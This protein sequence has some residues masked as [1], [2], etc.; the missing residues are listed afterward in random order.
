MLAEKAIHALLMADSAVVALV[1]TRCGPPPLPQPVTLPALVVEH[2]STVERTTLD[3]QSAYGLVE[4]RI[5]VTI[6]AAT[7][8]AAKTLLDAVRTACNYKRGTIGGVRVETVQRVNVGADAWDD[9]LQA[10]AQSIDFMVIH[11]E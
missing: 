10:Y 4:S 1:G 6:L 3:A 8:G 9:T 5:E 2:I 7:Y 11:Q